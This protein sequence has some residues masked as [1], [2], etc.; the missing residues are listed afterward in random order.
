[1]KIKYILLLLTVAIM[2]ACSK[3]D[4]TGLETSFM[5]QDQKFVGR[6]I[7][8]NTGYWLI[9]RTT[10]QAKNLEL[11][12]WSTI[13]FI[14]GLTYYNGQKS[15]TRD[16]IGYFIDAELFNEKIL[17]ATSRQILS[18]DRNLGSSVVKSAQANETFRLMDKD[19]TGNVW[20]LSNK[21]IYSMKGET[22]P[23]ANNITAID[24]ETPNG[25]SFWIASADSVYHFSNNI[26]KKISVSAISG[27]KNSS[28]TIYSLK[29]D[30]NNNIWINTSAMVYRYQNQSW[31]TE[32][33][34]NFTGDNFKTVPFMDV[35]S[36]G[37]LWLA[38]KHYQAFT[39]LH[40]YNGKAWTSYKLEPQL[41]NW[42]NDIEVTA[43]GEVLIATNNG[44]K[45][46]DLK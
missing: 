10:N 33:A 27:V 22:I 34:G 3:E 24:F 44:L 38:E 42:V 17:T 8:D 30:N 36:K 46:L 28:A 15:V 37:N 12:S 39:N 6:I 20:I 5:D 29:V 21:A 26:L 14:D 40:F 2:F 32:R 13:N 25:T 43:A 31:N 18:F 16:A 45:K 19:S 9:T 1:M 4:E 7:T 35:D 41:E 11:N 23:F